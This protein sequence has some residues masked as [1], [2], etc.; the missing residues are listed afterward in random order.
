MDFKMNLIEEKNKILCEISKID[1]ITILTTIEDI[2]NFNFAKRYSLEPLTQ[3]D[4]I[5]RA[6][7]SETDIKNNQTLS[8]DAL[9]IEINNW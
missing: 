2:I 6:L 5:N 7:I 1:D 9:E 8:L 3:D 4:I